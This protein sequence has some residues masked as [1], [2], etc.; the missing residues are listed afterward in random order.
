MPKVPK[1]K[2]F[3]LFCISKTDQT[4]GYAETPAQTW[5]APAIV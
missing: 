2:V 5:I 4:E 1:I 3:C